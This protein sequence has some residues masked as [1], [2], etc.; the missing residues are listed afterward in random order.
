[1]KCA[2]KNA[3]KSWEPES[4]F[5]EEK[6]LDG[7]TAQ[8]CG[9]VINALISYESLTCEEI[10]ELTPELCCGT[11]CDIENI[12]IEET[13]EKIDHLIKKKMITPVITKDGLEYK[14]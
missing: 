3:L 5:Y 8:W 11:D 9:E 6:L 2:I 13:Q 4:F 14:I 7:R 1:M 12:T 10:F